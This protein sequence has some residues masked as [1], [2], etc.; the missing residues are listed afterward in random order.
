MSKFFRRTQELN[1]RGS[2][3]CSTTW[4]TGCK[5]HNGGEHRCTCVKKHRDEHQCECPASKSR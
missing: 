3:I 1:Q 5:D 2:R 4:G